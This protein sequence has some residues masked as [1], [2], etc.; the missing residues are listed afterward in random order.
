ML[1]SERLRKIRTACGLTQTDVAQAL[2]IERTTYTYYET[3]RHEPSLVRTQEIAKL[4]NIDIAT[5]LGEDDIVSGNFAVF[6]DVVE[7]G[8][9][10]DKFNELKKDEAMLLLYYRRLDAGKKARLLKTVKEKYV[11]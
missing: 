5:L 9:E 6:D 4:F 1:F 2:G 11:K 7:Y 8:A 10:F 3:G